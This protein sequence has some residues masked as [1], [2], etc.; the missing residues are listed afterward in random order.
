MSPL[1]DV[2]ILIYMDILPFV[3]EG[4]LQLELNEGSW[5]RE[6]IL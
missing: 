4:T 1:K 3:A 5:S 2:R 6:I